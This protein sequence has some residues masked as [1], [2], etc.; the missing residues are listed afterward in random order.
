MYASI[1]D[2]MNNIF[3]RNFNAELPQIFCSRQQICQEQIFT[4]ARRASIRT[5]RV[6]LSTY[7]PKALAKLAGQAFPVSNWNSFDTV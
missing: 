4:Q 2:D 1:M 6:N 5:I 3:E 7:I